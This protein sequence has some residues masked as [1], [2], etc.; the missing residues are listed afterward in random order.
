VSE[1]EGFH[2]EMRL[3]GDT[4]METVEDLHL[5][6][7]PPGLLGSLAIWGGSLGGGGLL[8]ITSRVIVFGV[9]ELFIYLRVV[10]TLTGGLRVVALIV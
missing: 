8:T 9:G 7:S 6:G 5:G 10:L 2:G 1:G 3:L 4:S